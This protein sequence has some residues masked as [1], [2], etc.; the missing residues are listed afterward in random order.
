[1]F[2]QILLTKG[3]RLEQAPPNSPQTNGYRSPNNILSEC[4]ATI[5]PIYDLGKI[6]PFG[7]KVVVR[8]ENHTSKV[9]V[10]GRSMRALTFEPFSDALRVFDPSTG[11]V[12]ITRDFAQLR[13]E[14]SIILWEDPSSLPLIDNPPPRQVATLPV[15]KAED[16]SLSSQ[17]PATTRKP[18][19]NYAPHDIL[20]DLIAQNILKGEKHQRRSPDRLMLAD[21]I[22]YKQAHSNPDE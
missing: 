4:R 18:R 12:S 8:N 19:Y 17:L 6:I 10:T 3:I 14:T 15:L 11:K 16:H 7:I 21:V 22:T 5:Q 2:P 20:S 1:M 9:N 13:S